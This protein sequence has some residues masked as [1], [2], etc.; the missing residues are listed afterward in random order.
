MQFL[1]DVPLPQANL[2]ERIM[3]AIYQN[4]GQGVPP[5]AAAVAV[6]PQQAATPMPDKRR[7]KGFP[8]FAWVS[9]AAVLLAVGFISYQQLQDSQTALQVESSQTGD[10]IV[11]Y[12]SEAG[13]TPGAASSSPASARSAADAAGSEQPLSR[14]SEATTETAPASPATPPVAPSLASQ[15]IA[16]D[17]PQAKTAAPQAEEQASAA[18]RSVTAGSEGQGAN[19]KAAPEK[20]AKA[21]ENTLAAA[22]KVGSPAADQQAFGTATMSETETR[23]KESSDSVVVGPT[24]AMAA[25][26]PI[27][28]STFSDTDTAVQ[29][30]DMPV[31]V[32][33][34]NANSFS[35][36][37]ISVQYESETSQKV[38]RLSAEY[39]RN[40]D[41]IRIEV[42]RNTK[43][44]RSLSIP[45]TFSATQ[46]FAV[47]GEQAIAVSFDNPDQN[48]SVAEHA[49]H[50]NAQS[51]N[52]SL[53]VIVTAHGISLDELIETS[54]QMSWKP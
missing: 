5:H 47:N 33:A 38:T 37:T 28:L 39:K 25:K 34:Q 9:A 4:A 19:A 14:A 52:Q 31:P 16:L 26:Q 43:G 3:Q 21:P 22:K 24:L 50:F 7:T 6:L 45:G 49:V 32:L 54:K 48:S 23:Q 17:A 15:E 29:A 27:T 51:N 11:A 46:L 8:S 13:Q 35:L 40:D 30:S 12:S 18:S 2:E 42:V 1:K 44:K 20:E 53:Y 36:R 41:W 10:P